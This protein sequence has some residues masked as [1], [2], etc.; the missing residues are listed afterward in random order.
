MVH[1]GGSPGTPDIL[2]TVAIAPENA[3]GSPTEAQFG[4]G[5][6]FNPRENHSVEGLGIHFLEAKLRPGSQV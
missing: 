5:D 3:G 4:L 1:G 2:T 6:S